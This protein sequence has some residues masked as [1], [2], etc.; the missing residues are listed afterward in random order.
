ME[1][2]EMG[3]GL[4]ENCRIAIREKLRVSNHGQAGGEIGERRSQHRHGGL[5][6]PPTDRSAN[7][8]ILHGQC[9]GSWFL[10]GRQF[11]LGGS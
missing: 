1:K 11:P 4:V 10:A 2:R 8:K 6:H 5:M 9:K 3:R 7:L